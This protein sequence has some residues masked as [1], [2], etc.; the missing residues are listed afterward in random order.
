M[1][2]FTDILIAAEEK[3]RKESFRK[4]FPVRSKNQK[5]NSW[6]KP[7]YFVTSKTFL[8]QWQVVLLFVCTPHGLVN[9]SLRE[10]EQTLFL[11][12]LHEYAEL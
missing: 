4:D 10:L 6:K 7:V 3:F 1:C 12:I 2:Y 5:T 8:L 11:F 9:S